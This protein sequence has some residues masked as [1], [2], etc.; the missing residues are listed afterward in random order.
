MKFRKRKIS[1]APLFI[2]FLLPSS[3][4]LLILT[5]SAQAVRTWSPL[6]RPRVDHSLEANGEFAEAILSF[7][8]E[9]LRHY[10]DQPDFEFEMKVTRWNSTYE[11]YFYFFK[12]TPDS[13][14]G[15]T[16]LCRAA[17]F[18]DLNLVRRILNRENLSPDY[19]HRRCWF[20]HLTSDSQYAELTASEVA[21][22]LARYRS[23]LH[24]RQITVEID[25]HSPEPKHES[26]LESKPDDLLNSLP[27]FHPPALAPCTNPLSPLFLP[28]QTLSQSV[29]V[30]PLLPI[31]SP[32]AAAAGPP[33]FC[34][35]DPCD[36][37][38][39]EFVEDPDYR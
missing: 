19:V 7:D 23:S 33:P 37:W 10:A 28:F 18:G 31:C 39:D 9:K 32:E 29:G 6:S 26:E 30:P 17:Q 22:Y 21:D 24:Y 12:P 8:P 5:S 15:L 34:L 25:T 13:G 20:T 1:T 27:E 14:P 3:V 11:R 4:F 38:E 35:E 16:A 2:K 36:P